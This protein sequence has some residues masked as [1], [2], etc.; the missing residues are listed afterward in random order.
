MKI[1]VTGAAGYIGSHAIRTIQRAGHDVVALDNL[2]R[3]HR[4][5][6]PEGVPFVQSDVGDRERVH[7][8]LVEHRIE[9]VVHFAAYALVGESVTDPLLYFRNNTVGTLGL[10]E[11]ML[12]AGVKKL[13]FSST[14]A[15]YGVPDT[16]PIHEELPQSP[17]NPYGWSK[18]FSERMMRDLCAAT[19]D[20]SV[21]ALRYFNVAGCA[22]DGTLGEDHVP[23]TH[24]IP[25]IFLALLGV[26]DKITVF[27]DDY[28][29][30]DGTCIRDYVHV[31]D[32]ADAHVVALEKLKP[33]FN[34]YNLGIGR[35]DSVKEILSATE[36][37]VGRP[38]PIEIGPRR[39]G[40]PP[41]LYADPKKIERELGWRARRTDIRQTIESAW[42]WF[43]KH[44]RGYASTGTK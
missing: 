9:G 44:P 2:S 27:G 10:L 18:L 37:V 31:E 15:T 43:Q 5:A 17:I 36:A 23:E 20:L 22:E 29:T 34:A 21:A 28:P 25:S 7:A 26:R 38:M 32:L 8:A 4:E 24:L 35:G 1:L 12:A 40:D 41:A 19:P 16:I 3:G 6:L 14:C 11:A 33:G 30:P 42:R 39:P 13:V